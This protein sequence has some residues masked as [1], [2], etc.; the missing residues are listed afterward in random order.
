[1][2]A[3]ITLLA[4]VAGYLVAW[5]SRQ[6]SMP[7]VAM[8]HVDTAQ[9]LAEERERIY[10]DLHDDLGAKLLTIVH[11]SERKSKQTKT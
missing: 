3:L 6:R 10:A 7:V 2:T 11:T 9:A 8:P 4:F 5:W 1:M